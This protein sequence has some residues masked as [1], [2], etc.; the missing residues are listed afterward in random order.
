MFGDRASIGDRS[1]LDFYRGEAKRLEALAESTKEAR[2]KK[3]A[4]E[5][6]EEKGSEHETDEDVKIF[7][8][9]SFRVG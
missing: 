1:Q 8:T 7:P 6:E 4:E 3:A 2:D 5:S 9:L